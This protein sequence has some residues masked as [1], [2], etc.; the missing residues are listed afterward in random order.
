MKIRT[1]Q[2]SKEVAGFVV[3]RLK[4]LS[5]DSDKVLRIFTPTGSTPLEVYK[6]LAEEKEHWS[7]RI[8]PIQIDEFIQPERIF[9]SQLKSQLLGPLG[10]EA[11]C[12]EPSWTDAEM[13]LHIDKV[14]SR[15]IDLAL[16]GLGPNGHVGF[17]EPGLDASFMGGRVEISD[18][19][20]KR[21]PG[22]KTNQAFTFG[23]GTFLKAH[24]IILM[25]TG[26]RKR[27][28]LKKVMA[29]DPTPLI[30]ATLLK[31]HPRLTIVTDLKS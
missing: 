22:A 17:H 27:A 14:L 24:D 9:Y 12:I 21:V 11:E 29:L 8:A 31:T 25:V 4:E 26:E 10:L 15:T 20:K 18:E 6:A 16:L 2:T 5:E 23:V 3:R 30:P 28:I 7:S 19:T 13:I 1:C